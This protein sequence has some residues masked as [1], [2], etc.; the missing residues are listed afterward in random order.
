[1]EIGSPD[2][3]RSTRGRLTRP[4]R[5]LVRRAAL[6]DALG[7]LP[8]LAAAVLGRRGSGR[9]PLAVLDAP[10]TPLARRVEEAAR[11][12]QSPAWLGHGLRSVAFAHA[13]AALDGIDADP[14]LLWCAC[15][16]HDVAIEHP[17]PGEC[18]AVRGGEIARAAAREAGASTEDAERLADAISRHITPGLDPARHPLPYLV[19]G[20]ALVDVLG[21]RLHRLDP[22]FVD[23]VLRT[24]PRGDFA[25]VVAAAW[26]AEART[27]PAGRA[28]A[29]ERATCL[30]VV[31][32]RAPVS[33]SRR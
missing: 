20:G 27:V 12:G 33:T 17:V 9:A 13:V 19:A 22:A 6:R 21:A 31:A 5:R 25:A 23:D 1:M 29:I 7:T 32:R 8:G 11:A 3:G 14:E 24:H 16:L 28:A 26:R 18:F 4:E 10:D 30:S 2:W 15:L